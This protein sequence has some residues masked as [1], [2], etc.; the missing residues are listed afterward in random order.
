[1]RLDVR[2]LVPPTILLVI[3]ALVFVPGIPPDGLLAAHDGV[4]YFVPAFERPGPIWD[5]YLFGGFPAV[6]DPQA[7]L[8]YPP[9]AVLS[10]VAGTWNAFVLLAYVL[11]AWFM[12]RL[13]LEWTGAQL[14][15]LLAALTYVLGGFFVSHLVHASVIHTAAW[16]PLALLGAE[17]LRRRPSGRGVAL[18]AA[19]IGMGALA[20]HPQT[21]AY[22]LLVLVAWTLVSLPAAEARGRFAAS[23][24]AAI[25]LGLGLAAVLVLPA[26]DLVAASV[27][28]DI[29]AGDFLEFALPP[30]QWPQLLVPYVFGGMTTP[31]AG[32]WFPWELTGYVG[33]L[34]SVLALT[35]L[36][37]RPRRATVFF[38]ATAGVAFLLAFGSATPLG[39][40][41]HA[42]PGLGLFRAP[43]RHLFE[44]GFAL[45]VL[46]GLGMAEV[47][48]AEPARRA[49]A[50]RAGLGVAVP[51]VVALLVGGVAWAAAVRGMAAGELFGRPAVL[52]A[53]AHLT[54]AILALGLAARRR[55]AGIALLLVTVLDLT[56]FAW[57]QEWRLRPVPRDTFDEPSAVALHRQRL[58]EGAHR[59]T[60]L[61]GVHG[62]D[63]TGVPNRSRLWGLESTSGY[64]PLRLRRTVDL[65]GL[66]L[67]GR[68][69][70]S[71]LDPRH[72]G[73]D[74]LS[75][76]ILAVK[77][78]PWEIVARIGA[79]PRWTAVGGTDTAVFFENGNVLPRAWTVSG[80]RHLEPA[81]ALAAVTTGRFPAGEPFDP[82]ETAIVE[83]PVE[84]VFPTG[85]PP[86]SIRPVAI[87]P[88]RI[89]YELE[90]GRA[91]F[92]VLSEI[93]HRGWRARADGREVPV[94]RCDYVLCGVSIPAGTRRLELTFRPRSLEIGGMIS[95]LCLAATVV[96]GVGRR[97]GRDP[98][99]DAARS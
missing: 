35:A 97:R 14:P 7:M 88:G 51:V 10:R 53:L 44:L 49:R 9:A 73:L 92:A 24:T 4:A 61:L 33:V 32:K 2:R 63:D 30:E 84:A 12:H 16:A 57:F 55:A 15:S 50:A 83:G 6:G 68:P 79:M 76:K 13:V 45:S 99:S 28:A 78:T 29:S 1:M 41:M 69:A 48:H 86:A 39:P 80:V 75:S 72:R 46:A 8:W 54:L 37:V 18:T 91:G 58:A 36:L 81:A 87:R 98:V 90:S 77:A 71:T 43:S 96:L 64:N 38:G 19:A 56:S 11:G 5:P 21:L 94:V 60:P 23:V 85:A 66:D 89:L 82:L 22:T 70:W 20:G 27:R 17:R 93:F 25:G 52:V 62:P 42:I 3:V 67:E 34:P 47:T 95:A 74:L 65:L 40:A 26:R 59:W 31:Y